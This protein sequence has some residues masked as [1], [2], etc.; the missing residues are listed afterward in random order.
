[1]ELAQGCDWC[2][3]PIYHWRPQADRSARPPGPRGFYAPPFELES[4]GEYAVF[5]A[6]QLANPHI[7]AAITPAP[8]DHANFQFRTIPHQRSLPAR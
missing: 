2:K 5:F 1:M 3:L 8:V 7:S 6:E 4:A